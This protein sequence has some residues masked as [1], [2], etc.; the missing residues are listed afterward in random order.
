MNKRRKKKLNKKMSQYGFT[1]T[2]KKLISYGSK[3]PPKP[4]IIIS[5]R[6]YENFFKNKK[7]LDEV[8]K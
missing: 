2:F 6:A 8:I 4:S 3:N 1:E 5:Q 7:E